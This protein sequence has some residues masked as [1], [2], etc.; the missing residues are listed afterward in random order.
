MPV[1]LLAKSR[2]RGRVL[3]LEQ[4]CSETEQAASLVFAEGT[5][6]SRNWGRFFRLGDDDL[7]R[8]LVNLRVAALFH[9][10]GK[11]NVEF[12]AAVE[13]VGPPE[14]QTVRHEHFS[15][16]VL[17]LPE[18]RAW[19]DDSP[20]LDADVITGAVLSHH[21][22]ADAGDG[23]PEYVWCRPRS[24][25]TIVPL[26]I[27]H[28][29]VRAIFTRVQEIAELG[30]P[31]P[32]PSEPWMNEGRWGQALT[33]GKQAATA[34]R[35][36]LRRR[37]Q[38]PRRALLLAVKTGLIVADSV[39]SAMFREERSLPEWID[40]V[41]HSPAL[42]VDS[43]DDA[44]ITPRTQSIA[45]STNK[46]FSYHRFQELAGEQGRRALL[47]AGC[48][49]GKTMAAWRW[50]RR[51]LAEEPLGRVIFL[52]P[53]RGTATEGFRD[54]VGWAP[55]GE[56]TLVHGSAAYEL[57]DMAANPS[58]ALR[59]KKTKRDEASARL[60]A[61]GLWTARYFSATVDQFLAFLEHSY[62]SMC[63]LPALADAAVIIDEIHSFDR[64]MFDDLISFLRCFD[65]PV[66]CM[67][68]TLPASR[69][70]ELVQAGLRVFPDVTH[71]EELADLEEQET[72]PRYRL[73]RLADV[74]EAFVR[75]LAEY[76]S[77]RRILWVVNTV[78]RCQ[79]AARRLIE[80][81]GDGVLVYHSR[82]RFEDRKAAH[83]RTVAAFQ[84]DG[85]PIIAVT[86][87]VC[88]MSLDL[89]AD[90]L[91]TELAPITSLVQRFGRSNRS[92]RRPRGFRSQLC[93][94]E[95]ANE[96]PYDRKELSA[97]RQFLTEFEGREVSQREL[98]VALETMGRRERIATG[99]SRFLEGGYYATP[100]DFRDSDDYAQSCVLD[101]DVPRALELLAARRSLDGLC[102]PVPRS[103]VTK[104]EDE[105]RPA[106]LP[107]YLGI[108]PSRRYDSKLGF[109]ARTGGEA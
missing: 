18:I 47:I 21:L 97:A 76:R 30:H 58:E 19:L 62:D 99:S 54:Y 25:R 96:R 3:T 44:I 57:E 35:R 34:F 29:E 104:L 12:Q 45:K 80:V 6:W 14:T 61:L 75:A 101:C 107:R 102:L 78:A 77:G 60:Y 24:E 95:P 27:G 59:G 1:A 15:A 103:S 28:P 51:Q 79:E 65:V 63:L 86:T 89:D 72:R 17:S 41:A 36:R 43:L 10:I 91:L 105:E 2:H 87:Q 108:A 92:S 48:G 68:A 9:D 8:F 69:R 32:L 46:P 20:L 70:E 52:Y 93:V 39:A 38:E 100:G 26:H 82:F 71:R 74:E 4:H 83:G 64:S 85:G 49:A 73:A 16:L 55:E 53:T 5:R 88:E 31:P 22:K 66:L 11:A 33:R 50:A 23:P 84:G 7:R 90:V 40:R 42:T 67:T 37:D 13:R 56:G 109:V 94:Y 106:K 81:L 98:A